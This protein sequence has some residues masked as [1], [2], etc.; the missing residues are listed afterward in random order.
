MV[1]SKQLA[2]C[3]YNLDG[4]LEDVIIRLVFQNIPPSVNLQAQMASSHAICMC[5]LVF[6]FVEIILEFYS[7][8][9]C[10]S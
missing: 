9:L 4:E 6:C 10:L 7:D 2:I 3:I 8:L 5:F 1:G